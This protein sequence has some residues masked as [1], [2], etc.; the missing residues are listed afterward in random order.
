MAVARRMARDLAADGAIAVVLTGSSALGEAHEES[1][2][3]LVAVYTRA[4][5]T[6]WHERWALIRRE[7]RLVSVSGA[8]PASVRA[9][10]GDPRLIPTYVPG[11]RQARILHDPEGVGKQLRSE[12]RA[13]RWDGVAADCDA[14][15]ADAITGWCEEVH[16]LAG[17]V[18]RGEQMAAGVQRSL[19]A[20]RIAPIVA[21]HRRMLYGSENRL[22]D[23]VAELMGEPWASTQRAALS[24]DGESWDVSARAALRLFVLAAEEVS[25][26]LNAQQRD[27]VAHA[28]A[29]AEG[30]QH[31]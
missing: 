2:L 7:G 3:D 16:K 18:Q 12:A 10:F 5:G 20:I 21:L 17:M 27:V 8:T 23:V 14:W 19:L 4:R 30:M 24:L 6:R 25:D 31:S 28:R 9:S 26:V 29:L 22:W 1:D 15:V 13:F 11:W